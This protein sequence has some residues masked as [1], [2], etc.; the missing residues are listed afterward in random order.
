ME[1]VNAKT[2]G[3]LVGTLTLA[4]AVRGYI[5]SGQTKHFCQVRWLLLANSGLNGISGWSRSM[6]RA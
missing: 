5:D 6:S 4:T 1:P 2:H 3:G